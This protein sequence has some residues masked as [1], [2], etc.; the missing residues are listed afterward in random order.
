[1]YQHKSIR[2]KDVFIVESHEQVVMP[3]SIIRRGLNTTPSLITLDHHTD[4]IMA[5]H[6]YVFHKIQRNEFDIPDDFDEKYKAL[7]PTLIK[8]IVWSD[9]AAIKKSI[10]KLDHDEHIDAAIRA[11]IISLATSINLNSF[12]SDS[13]ENYI[14]E[15]TSNCAL[16]CMKVPHDDDCQIAHYNQVIESEYLE[17]MLAAANNLARAIG[18]TNVESSPYILDID[19]DYFHTDKSI[20]PEHPSTL[21]RLI[22]NA[23]AVTIALEPEC[24]N[25]LRLEG[26]SITAESLLGDML[27]NISKAMAESHLHNLERL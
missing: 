16:G 8:Q 26:A 7:S 5:F 21:Y 12:S 23:E 6:D 1:M 24:V 18:V 25:D 9:D 10:G 4:T 11:G 17:S 14:I 3:W 13:L 20:N 19:L 22:R 27:E 2:S 15:V